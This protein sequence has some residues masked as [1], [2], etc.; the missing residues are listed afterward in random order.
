MFIQGADTQLGMIDNYILKLPDPKWDKEVD[1][2]RRSVEA[3]NKMTP[4]PKFYIVCGDL[5]DAFPGT[6]NRE[7]QVSDFKKAFEKLDKDIPLVCVCGNHDVGSTPTPDTIQKFRSDHGPDYFTFFVQG[8]MCIVLNSQYYENRTQVQDLAAEQDRWL[9]EILKRA[10]DFKHTI[11][12]QHIPWFLREPGEEKEYF[13]IEYELRLKMLDKFCNAGVRTIFCGH[14]HR[15]AGG[16]FK[17]LEL[18][19]TSAVGA[20]LGT[21]K[22]GLR[23]VHVDEDCIR[24][25]Y[26]AIEDIPEKV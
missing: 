21:D 11:V 2:V 4:K 3:V 26:Y 20:Q 13:N 8:V 12:F 5:V 7:A 6:P 16:K 18:I 15:N 25:K 19:V 1:L 9:D 23:V 14:Y 22:S 24:H 10:K 17:N